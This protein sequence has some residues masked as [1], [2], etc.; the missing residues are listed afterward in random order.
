MSNIELTR[1]SSPN[2][3]NEEG[4]A[5]LVRCPE[6]KE[7][8]YALNVALGI[9]TWCGYDLNETKIIKKDVQM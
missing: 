8:N 6:C 2:F 9:C 3:C 4:R 5:Y 1:T 7:T